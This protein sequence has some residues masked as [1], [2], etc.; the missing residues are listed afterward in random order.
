MR[1]RARLHPDQAG[2]QL[3]KEWQ[4]LAPP[5]PAS[6]YHRPCRIDAMHLEHRL[7]EINADRD[8]VPF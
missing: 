2:R 3:L 6:N 8:N 5:Q 1:R 4:H 7:G